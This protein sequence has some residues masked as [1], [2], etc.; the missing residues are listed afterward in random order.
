[1]ICY[2][3]LSHPVLAP[4]I[5]PLRQIQVNETSTAS[6]QVKLVKLEKSCCPGHCSSRAVFRLLINVHGTDL[7]NRA[8]SPAASIIHPIGEGHHQKKC[9]ADTQEH[10]SQETEKQMDDTILQTQRME[11]DK[12]ES[13]SPFH[14]KEQSLLRRAIKILL[15]LFI[16]LGVIVIFMIACQYV[17]LEW[18]RIVRS[19]SLN[20]CMNGFEKL[21]FV[22]MYNPPI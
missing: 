18:E 6:W 13:E 14:Q 4:Q 21:R 8:S 2:E 20:K 7:N 17:Y 9:R 1:R 12:E 15:V 16:I 5:F 10:S 19:R 3:G 22:G 11:I